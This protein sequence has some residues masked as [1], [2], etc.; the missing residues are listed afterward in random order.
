MTCENYLAF[1]EAHYDVPWLPLLPKPLGAA[2]LRLLGR[3]PQFLLKAVTYTTYPG[4]LRWCREIGFV[5]ARDA[6]LAQFLREKTGVKWRLL[7][8]LA[9]V[10]GGNGPFV[11]ERARRTFTFGLHELYRK[12]ASTL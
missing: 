5:R 4:V 7:R 10:T 11:L 2:Y 1:W 8:A 9:A 12:P 3:S 6:E